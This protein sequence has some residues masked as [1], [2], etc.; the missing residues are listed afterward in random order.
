[1]ITKPCEK[2]VSFAHQKKA[3]VASREGHGWKVAFA[4]LMEMGTGKSKVDI[5]ETCEMSLVGVIDIWIIVAPKGVY[6]NWVNRELLVH[7]WD[8]VSATVEIEHWLAGGGGKA[9]RAALERLLV[10]GAGLRVFVVNTEAFSTGKK[11]WVYVVQ[12]LESSRVG[13]KVSVDESTQIKNDSNRKDA[14]VE[15]GQ[16]QNVRYRRILTGSPVTRSPLDLFWQFF[17]LGKKLLGFA[18]F[19]SFRARYAV[20]KQQI[21]GGRKVQ[22]VVGYRDTEDLAKRIAPHSFRV[23]KDECLDLPPKVYEIRE[24]EL[25]DEQARIYRGIREHATAALDGAAH[26]TATE[27]ITQILRLHQVVCGHVVDEEGFTHDIPSN[28]IPALMDALA[29]HSGKAIIWS[30]YRRDIEKIVAALTKEYGPTSVVQFHGGID[31]EKRILAVR[32]FQGDETAAHDPACRWMVSNQQTGGYGNTWT[33]AD[34][35]VFYSNDYSLEKRLQAEDRPHRAGQTK[36]VTVLDLLV[37]GTVEEKILKALRANIDI[38]STIMG[39]GYREWL[40]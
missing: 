23:R 6:M 11:A 34:L 8:A 24:V 27:V 32:R 26:V 3:R 14:V 37:R 12:L 38:A 40:I 15:L 7:L 20:M 28:R 18:S 10:P 30:R 22:I 1:M 29:E 21:F 19:Y 5:D 13:V 33:E 36:S 16:H 4:W 17:F 9:H 39:D 31:S 2:T 25:T 35:E